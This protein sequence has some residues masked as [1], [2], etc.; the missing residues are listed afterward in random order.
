MEMTGVPGLSELKPLF[1]SLI[2]GFKPWEWN[3]LLPDN[4]QS[5]EF[6]RAAFWLSV[7]LILVLSGVALVTV[8]VGLAI[9]FFD[10]LIGS[11]AEVF[12]NSIMDEH[13]FPGRL[14]L[15]EA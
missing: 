13:Y 5:G 15:V 12:G 4:N 14:F 6:W 9:I 1:Q 2:A 8:F 7:I 11:G 10:G 3:I